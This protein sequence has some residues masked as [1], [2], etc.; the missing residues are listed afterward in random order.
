M[1]LE[2]LIVF[3]EEP[4]M[5]AALEI[6]LP[7]ML[8]GIDFQ[9]IRFQC[10]Q[11]LLLQLPSRLKGYKAWLPEN[12]SILVL[13]DRDNDDCQKLKAQLEA[14]AAG[15][16]LMTKT[17]AGA[18]HRFKVTNRIVIEELESWYFGDW[19]A[20][21]KAFPKV[22]ETIPE[23]APFRNPDAIKGGTWEAFERILKRAGYFSTGLRKTECARQI[24]RYMDV[25]QNRSHSFRVF[26]HA[27]NHIMA[28]GR[29]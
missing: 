9:I 4:S 3:V 2:K 11:D 28:G 27:V 7:R 14:H 13:V 21:K 1:M 16:G 19:Q 22:P 8:A 26:N 15:A 25:T 29:A 20:V 18:S 6:I 5:E 24:A 12:W 10:K 23:K 17:Q